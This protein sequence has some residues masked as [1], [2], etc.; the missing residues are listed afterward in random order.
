MRTRWVCPPESLVVRR[1]A[2]SSIPVT[3]I[4]SSMRERVRVQRRDHVTEL[5]NAQVP[6]QR[7]GLEHAADDSRVDRLGGR[8]T[9]ER[10]G[11][12]VG[13]DE[14]EHHVDRGRLAGTVRTEQRQR[15]SRCDRDIDAPNG[16]H[17]AIGLGET[18]KTHAGAA[19]FGRDH[20]TTL[21]ALRPTFAPS[22]FTG[23]A[24]I[25]AGSRLSVTT[26]SDRA[27]SPAS[28]RVRI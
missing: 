1:S 7:A 17:V 28:R 21:D 26:C 24:V 19:S 9:K 16:L 15:L 20:R 5:A 11:A 23:I 6:R 13:P 14:S 10:D 27:I 25:Y 18:G 8:L 4:T 12:R 2:I 3:R 22:G